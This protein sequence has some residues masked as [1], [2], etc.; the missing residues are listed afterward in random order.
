MY[1]KLAPFFQKRKYKAAFFSEKHTFL[2]DALRQSGKA[3]KLPNS[4]V[5]CQVKWQSDL[6]ICRQSLCPESRAG[7]KEGGGNPPPVEKMEKSLSVTIMTVDSA[8]GL[9]VGFQ[10]VA[11][12]VKNV[13]IG[14]RNVES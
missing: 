4:V 7:K 11:Q 3:G 2:T 8:S 9:R 1:E 6:G 14:N 10:I 5:S 13:E 12:V